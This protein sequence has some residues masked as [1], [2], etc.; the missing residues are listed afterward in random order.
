M[1]DN[2]PETDQPAVDPVNLKPEVQRAPQ[3]APGTELADQQDEVAE[4]LDPREK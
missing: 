1:T 4:K 2:K 3:T